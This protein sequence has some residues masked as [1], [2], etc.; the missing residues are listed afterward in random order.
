MDL[1]RGQFDLVGVWIEL[2]LFKVLVFCL[3]GQ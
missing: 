3:A 1:N 2:T